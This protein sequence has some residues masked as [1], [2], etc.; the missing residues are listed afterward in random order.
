MCDVNIHPPE[1]Q[2]EHQSAA[3]GLRRLQNLKRQQNGAICRVREGSHNLVLLGKQSPSPSGSDFF[4]P[5]L[6][7]HFF[8]GVVLWHLIGT[9]LHIHLCLMCGS[10]TCVCVLGMWTSK[11]TIPPASEGDLIYCWHICL[12]RN[13][14]HTQTQYSPAHESTII[15]RTSSPPSDRDLE[16]MDTAAVHHAPRF[17]P[18]I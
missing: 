11:N 17:P 12:F 16:F 4:T 1:T 3:A 18:V 5:L 10:L 8:S 14:T 2:K 6:S 15:Q 7:F 13:H 9:L